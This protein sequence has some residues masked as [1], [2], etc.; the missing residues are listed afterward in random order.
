MD[1]FVQKTD[2]GQ[3]ILAGFDYLL[4]EHDNVF[5]MGQ[6]LW[7]PWYVGNSMTDL[8]KNLVKIVL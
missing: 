6:G 7:S 1:D 4:S 2:F 3:A 8:D 5:V